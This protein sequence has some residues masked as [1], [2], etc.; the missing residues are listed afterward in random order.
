MGDEVGVVDSLGENVGE[1]E[2]CRVIL[3]DAVG[4]EFCGDSLGVDIDGDVV[5]EDT[6]GEPVGLDVGVE[7]GCLDGLWEGCEV[8]VIG[9]AVG[10]G[11]RKVKSKVV[12]S[13]NTCGLT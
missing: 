4:D 3:G 10:L 8:T 11:P 9:E 12:R 7:D 13:A 6:V 5:G 2:G 1:E